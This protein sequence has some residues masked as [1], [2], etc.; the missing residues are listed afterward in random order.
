MGKKRLERNLMEV[1]KLNE[2]YYRYYEK[3]LQAY[4]TFMIYKTIV[5]YFLKRTVRK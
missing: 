1:N 3:N 5:K 2:N 4:N